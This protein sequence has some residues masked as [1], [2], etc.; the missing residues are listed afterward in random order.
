[1]DSHSG[2][3]HHRGDEG[4]PLLMRHRLLAIAAAVLLLIALPGALAAAAPSGTFSGSASAVAFEFSLR[5]FNVANPQGRSAGVSAVEANHFPFAKAKGAGTCEALAPAESLMTLPCQATNTEQ[6]EVSGS[7]EQNP[8]PNPLKCETPSV[9][10]AISTVLNLGLACGNAHARITGDDP[11][12]DGRGN[13][14]TMEL[15]IIP[16]Q[17]LDLLPDQLE[18]LLPDA[19]K[20]IDARIGSTVSRFTSEGSVVTSRADASASVIV[21]GGVAQD[22]NGQPDGLLII[23]TGDAFAQA[24]W[25]GATPVAA[26]DAKPSLLTIRV[27]QPD[28]S[29]Q[30]VES[31][32]PGESVTQLNGTAL[33]TTITAAD[34]SV[35]QETIG[36]KGTA[37]AKAT[38]VQVYA[39]QGIGGSAGTECGTANC[40]GGLQLKLGIADAQMEGEVPVLVPQ[41]ATTGHEGVVFAAGLL[42]ILLAWSLVHRLNDHRGPEGVSAISTPS[43]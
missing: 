21:V 26:G 17:L 30:T 37:T 10:A 39:A 22:A 38:A 20:V 14:G 29:Y 2:V 35:T 36:P 5:A 23:E 4:K 12:A 13:A 15:V 3:A 43:R 7:G 32:R 8:D 42:A 19:P 34:S 6:V 28:G 16:Q 40:D 25:N 9:P 18:N 33:Q 27:R 1:M 41:L 11:F 31:P 24:S